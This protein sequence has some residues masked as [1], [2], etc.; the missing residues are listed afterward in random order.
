MKCLFFYW[1]NLDC[2]LMFWIFMSC[3]FISTFCLHAGIRCSTFFCIFNK[4]DILIFVIMS[5]F[6]PMSLMCFNNICLWEHFCYKYIQS[7]MLKHP[8]LG[9]TFDLRLHSNCIYF[10]RLLYLSYSLQTINQSYAY[11]NVRSISFN[12]YYCEPIIHLNMSN[13]YSLL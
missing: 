11:D 12:N 1:N 8:F 6:F 13:D 2:L 9:F 7:F 10:G 4:T 3:N 5:R